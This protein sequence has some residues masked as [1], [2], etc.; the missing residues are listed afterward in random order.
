MKKTLFT[1]TTL[2]LSQP[3][4]ASDHD[5]DHDHELPPQT[6]HQHG[7]AQLNLAHQEGR[8]WLEFISPAL[9]IV[10]F[11]HQPRTEAQ[12]QRVATAIEQLQQGEVLFHFTPQKSC[13]LTEVE[14]EHEHEHEETHS[15]FQIHYHFQCHQA[16]TSLRVDLFQHFPSL[17]EI[18]LQA[19]SASDQTAARLTPASAT[20]PLSSPHRH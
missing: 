16:P 3:L 19:I 9:D 7:T 18:E 10:G 5:H 14:H 11:E 4:V 6:R 2:M 8:L 15:E 13:Q 17:T 1:L 12:R 20:I